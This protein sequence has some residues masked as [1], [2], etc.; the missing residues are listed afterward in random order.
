MRKAIAPG[1]TTRA[2]KAQE[3]HVQRYVNLLVD[4][5][6]GVI[7]SSAGKASVIDIGPWF[8]FTTFDILGDLAFGESFD[9]LHSSTYHPWVEILFSAA[10]AATWIA[11]VRFYPR[12]Y[13]LLFKLI[14]PSLKK[15]SQDHFNHVVERVKRRMNYEMDRED[16]MSPVLKE[17]AKHKMSLQEINGSFMTLV[18]AGS[19]TS[20]TVLTGLMNHLVH[21]PQYLKRLEVEVRGLGQGGAHEVTLDSL[22]QLEWLN[23][24]LTEAL[25]LCTPVPWILPRRVP[26]SGAVVAGVGLPGRTRVSIQAYTMNRDPAN[27]HRADEFLPE[28]WLPDAHKPESE[29]YRDRRE[30]L[31][32]FSVGSRACIGLHLAWAEMRLIM[33]RLIRAFDF[34]EVEGE[35]LV[36]ESLRTFALV[37]KKQ[38]PV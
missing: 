36:W 20:A 8:N 23:A 13:S 12:V 3:T 9:C 16:L 2:L 10:K 6:S 25:R 37:E 33:T 26:A 15:M 22:R 27:W 35:R 28:R 4:R 30:S 31:Q 1:F 29:F 24:V 21:Q 34:E 5:L 11:A 19:E 32:P 17:D 18:V 7:D 38:D 14:P